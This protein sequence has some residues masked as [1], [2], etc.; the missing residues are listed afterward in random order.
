MPTRSNNTKNAIY[1]SK[2]PAEVVT[3]NFDFRLWKM[4]ENT[5]VQ[6]ATV[7]DWD[8]ADVDSEITVTEAHSGTVVQLK[9][10]GGL[11]ATRQYF[12][13]ILAVPTSDNTLRAAAMIV[14]TVS[15]PEVN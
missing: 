13:R 11:V 8:G 3:Y 10:S 14:L 4:F 1:I 2:T 9:I 6:S 15:Q 7:K 12:I 5:T